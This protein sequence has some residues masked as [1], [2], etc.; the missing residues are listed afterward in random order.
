LW[1]R[2]AL[3]GIF[4]LFCRDVGLFWGDLGLFCGLFGLILRDTRLFCGNSGHFCGDA[5]L[6]DDGHTVLF[7]QRYRAHVRRNR[8]LL[9]RRSALLQ[10]YQYCARGSKTIRRSGH[11]PLQLVDATH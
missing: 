3:R 9:R 10:R 2:K 11:V 7:W 5:G 1:K 8:A 4:W 6:F